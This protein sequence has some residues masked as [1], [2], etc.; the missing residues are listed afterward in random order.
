MSRNRQ[1]IRD[2][3]KVLQM[4]GGS[5]LGFAQAGYFRVQKSHIEGCIVY[6][7][8]SPPKKGIQFWPHFCKPRFVRQ[9]SFGDAVNF[10]GAI[11]DGSI[12]IYVL[13]KSASG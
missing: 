2:L 3:A 12:R 8:L 6:D 7:Q 5:P 4:L 11:I 13:V 9:K 10:F 1:R